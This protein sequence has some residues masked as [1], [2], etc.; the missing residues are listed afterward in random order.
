MEKNI[1]FRQYIGDRTE[2]DDYSKIHDFLVKSN[3]KEYTYGRFDWMMTNWEYLEDKYLEKIGIWEENEEIVGVT[4]FDHS[5]DV[6]FPMVLDGYEDLYPD[7]LDYAK[8]NM[9][10][11]DNPEF[12]IYASDNNDRLKAALHKKD[13]IATE[14]KDMVAVYDLTEDIP[15]KDLKDGYRI[16]SLADDENY[17]E[18]MRCM[19]KGFG[20]E[21]SGEEF[22]FGKETEQMNQAAY[23]NR[24]HL[25]MNLKLSIEDSEGN[26]VATCGMWYD[27]RSEIALIEPVCVIPKCRKLGLGREVVF[28]GLRRVKTLGAKCAVVGSNQQFYY[29][30][31][32]I[33]YSTGTM[34]IPKK[35]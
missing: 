15:S 16:V 19:F 20:H 5:L 6:I 34:W 13:Y 7:M 32:M 27:N 29:S 18:Y 22:I 35:Q 1:V 3:D 26:Y 24:K 23:R 28:E 30:L 9:V 31:G 10:K 17:E 21:E 2:K 4:L 33:P 25:D 11:E 14:Q 12:L 8:Q